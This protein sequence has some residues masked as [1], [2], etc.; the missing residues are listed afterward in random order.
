MRRPPDNKLMSRPSRPTGR[1]A[2]C[3]SRRFVSTKRGPI[4][5]YERPGVHR[6]C[7]KTNKPESFTRRYPLRSDMDSH[8]LSFYL[9]LSTSNSRAK[10]SRP[11][12]DNVGYVSFV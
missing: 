1:L 7:E 3:R 9:H 6:I 12:T 4:E 8:Y 2:L 11:R 5:L 10:S